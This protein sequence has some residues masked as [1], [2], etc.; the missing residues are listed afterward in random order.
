[1]QTAWLGFDV[2]ETLGQFNYLFYILDFFIPKSQAEYLP[3]KHAYKAF[4]RNVASLD[5]N[6][7]IGLFRPGLAAFCKSLRLLIE[8]GDIGGL[9][10]YSNNSSNA[11]LQFCVD[12]MEQW[13][14]ME[15]MFCDLMARYHPLRFEKGVGYDLQ[16]KWNTLSIAFTKSGCGTPSPRQTFFYDDIIHPDLKNILG[17]NY[18]QVIPYEGPCNKELLMSA[19]HSALMEANVLVARGPTNVPTNGRKNVTTN[20]KDYVLDSQYVN[21]LMR[22]VDSIP[23][24]N[25]FKH[26]IM[27]L[28]GNSKDAYSVL[29]TTMHG[30]IMQN[31]EKED[32]RK[33]QRQSRHTRKNT[34]ELSPVDKWLKPITRIRPNIHMGHISDANK[35]KINDEFAEMFGKKLYGGVTRRRRYHKSKKVHTKGRRSSHRAKSCK[36]KGHTR[37]R[38]A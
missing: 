28:F 14:Q 32:T 24:N 9:M 29:W 1:M 37:R 8:Q 12:V 13:T 27:N 20:V 16:K 2:D 7:R 34:S 26:D 3:I 33:A 19:L 36:G 15:D 18:I 6:G 25:L 23:Q 31:I 10:L 38:K 17:P 5:E 21:T 35:K 4:V 30:I 22:I 11:V